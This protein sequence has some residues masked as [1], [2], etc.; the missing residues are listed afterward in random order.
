M[1][2]NCGTNDITIVIKGANTGAVVELLM[3][4]LLKPFLMAF[5]V[6]I[7]ESNIM[8][9]YFHLRSYFWGQSKC[10]ISILFTVQIFQMI[11]LSNSGVSK[12][13]S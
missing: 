1:H 9:P 2:C 13:M 12:Y 3:G 8:P 7:I 4:I 10:Q 11:P 5:Y 6:F